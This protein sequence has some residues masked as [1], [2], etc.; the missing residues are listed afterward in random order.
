MVNAKL[1]HDLRLCLAQWPAS[2]ETVRTRGA[3]GATGAIVR[4]L[5]TACGC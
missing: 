3:A 5:S 2:D 1:A 4:A